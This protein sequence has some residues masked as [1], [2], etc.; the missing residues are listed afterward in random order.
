MKKDISLSDGEWKLMK[1]LWEKAPRTIGEMVTALSADTGW[2]KNTIF[3][4]LSRLEEKGAVR[5]EGGARSRLYYPSVEK[6]D[7]TLRETESFLQK[8]YGG[9]LGLMVASLAGQKTLTQDD[10]EE[11]YAVLRAAEEDKGQ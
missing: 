5:F 7:I 9:S 1:L 3:V 10:I 8:V 6:T 4:M 11:L 2:S